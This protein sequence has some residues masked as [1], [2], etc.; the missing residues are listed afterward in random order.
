MAGGQRYVFENHYKKGLP[1]SIYMSHTAK[2]ENQ[3]SA[4]LIASAAWTNSKNSSVTWSPSGIPSI[5]K[6]SIF[7]MDI[8]NDDGRPV[9]KKGEAAETKYRKRGP[10]KII[11]RIYHGDGA[12][13]RQKWHPPCLRPVPGKRVGKGAQALH[14]KQGE[15]PVWKHRVIFAADRG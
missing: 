7:D 1:D 4:V 2:M 6:G 11:V 13:D 3:P 12:F 5:T 15:E 10:E 8:F 14:H 9:D